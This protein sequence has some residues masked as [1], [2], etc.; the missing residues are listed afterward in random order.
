MQPPP[1]ANDT[2]LRRCI[3]IDM[4]GVDSGILEKVCA[5]CEI[6]QTFGE[7]FYLKFSGG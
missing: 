4:Y 2:W 5:V 3:L 1:L 6:G 7:S